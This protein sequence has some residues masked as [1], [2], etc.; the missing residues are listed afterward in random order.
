MLFNE[1]HQLIRE[2]ARKFAQEQLI[3]FSAQWD[4]NAEFPHTAIKEL[5]KLGFMGMLIPAQYGGAEV[6]IIG[7]LLAL[8]EIAAGDASCSTIMSVNNSVVCMPILRYGTDWQKEHFLIPLAQGT[9]LGAF[10][11]TEPQSGSHAAA[12][13][14]EARKEGDSFIINGTKQFITSGKNADI[15][16]VFATTDKSLGKKGISAFIIP[17]DTPGYQVTHLEEKMGQKASDTAQIV[18]EECRIPAKYLLGELG[19]GY[20]IAL[21]NLEGGRLG[22]AAQSI[23]IAQ[24]ALQIAMNYAKERETFG[25]FLYEH[26]VIRNYFA[27]MATDIEAATS[28]LMNAAMRYESNQTSLKQACMAKLF[29]SQMAERVCSQAMQILGGYGYLKDY[30]IEQLYRDVRV[31]QIY[32][33]TSEV[34][35]MVIAKEMFLT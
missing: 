4:A 16:I 13:S 10:C 8:I 20:K 23:G 2:T 31:T 35:K 5:G 14:T 24:A 12:M 29:A 15:A 18:L 1:E 27:E 26:S 22:I 9:K 30:R 34:Q 11:L 19:E 17:T 6:D 33:G 21:G 25:K 32:E 28:L 3:P 7:Y